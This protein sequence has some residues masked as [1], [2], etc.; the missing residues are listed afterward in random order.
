MP[1]LLRCPLG[2]L[3]PCPVWLSRLLRTAPS[4]PLGTAYHFIHST[5]SGKHF[6]LEDIWRMGDKTFRFK[7]DEVEDGA[8]GWKGYVCVRA[9]M[10]VSVG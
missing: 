8:T 1:A 5:S 9:F 10:C 7:M 2:W 3:L 4:Y 6:S